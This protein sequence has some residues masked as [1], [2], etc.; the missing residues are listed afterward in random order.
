MRTVMLVLGVGTN[1]ADPMGLI[2][3]ERAWA[4]AEAKLR[5]AWGFGEIGL[6]AE[7]QSLGERRKLSRV[8]R[9]W[10]H[11]SLGGIQVRPVADPVAPKG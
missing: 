1:K 11:Y 9:N 3:D 6:R 4:L 7:Q 5:Q 8:L 10:A 2:D